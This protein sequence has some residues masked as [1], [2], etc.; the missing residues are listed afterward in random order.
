MCIRGGLHIVT[1]IT[2][3]VLLKENSASRKC[4]ISGPNQIKW[5]HSFSVICLSGSGFLTNLSR[6]LFVGC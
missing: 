1:I 3:K 4:P 5:T 2:I 6:D